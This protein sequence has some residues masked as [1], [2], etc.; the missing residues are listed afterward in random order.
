MTAA[1]HA[2]SINANASSLV[3]S[4]PDQL[5]A[6]IDALELVHFASHNGKFCIRII[7]ACA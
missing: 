3:R 2:T 4:V 6:E 7:N 5:L 1:R